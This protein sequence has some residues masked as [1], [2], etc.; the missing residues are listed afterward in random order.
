MSLNIHIHLYVYAQIFAQKFQLQAKRLKSC[1]NKGNN[2][3][4]AYSSHM[5]SE[6]NR[7]QGIFL[8]RLV[9]AVGFDSS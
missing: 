4:V 2:E 5:K 7:R 6:I 9:R 3:Y 8:S 1:A